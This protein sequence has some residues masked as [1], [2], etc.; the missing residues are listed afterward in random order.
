MKKQIGLGVLILFVAL[1]EAA[2]QNGL[3]KHCEPN[4]SIKAVLCPDKDYCPLPKGGCLYTRLISSDTSLVILEFKV[5]AERLNQSETDFAESD[6]K[7]QYFSPAT[8]IIFNKL[9]QG[10]ELSFY[11][12]K[13]RNKQGQ[14]LVLQP[15]NIIV[16]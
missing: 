5:F 2:G 4:T 8:L 1:I 3:V 9:T 15:V 6:N 13:A 14:V 10:S 16:K 11:C 7:G 12:I